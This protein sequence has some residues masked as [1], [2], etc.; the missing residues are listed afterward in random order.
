VKVEEGMVPIALSPTLPSAAPRSA[1]R[2]HAT[3]TRPDAPLLPSGTVLAGVYEVRGLLGSG[4]MAQVFD[5]RDR[6]LD[7]RVA[8][9]IAW[10]NAVSALRA[11]GRALAALQHPS[12]VGVFHAGTQ[13]DLEYLVLEYIAGESLRAHLDERRLEGAPL[14]IDAGLALVRAIAGALA[15]V[16]GAGLSHRDLKPDNVMVAPGGR[17]VLTDFGLSRSELA[18]ADDDIGGSPGYMAPE[19]ILRRV[20]PGQGHL[21]DLYA[22]GVVAYE[23][24]VG[25]PPFQGD[26]WS[27]TLRAH[28]GEAPPDPR[29]QR[30]EVPEAAAQLVL[31]LLA[32]KPEERPR[33]AEDVARRLRIRPRASRGVAVAGVGPL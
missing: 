29:E 18:V 31:E 16:H 22:L 23:L 17:V 19:V 14:P 28:L 13:G 5:A 1:T 7:R 15:V 27:Q 11:E 30:P 32:K 25:R 26:H 10:P 24:L 6:A 33:S 21:V 3:Q 12:V 20:L 2:M 4:G 9:K 8:V